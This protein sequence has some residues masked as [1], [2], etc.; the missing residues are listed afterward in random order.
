V[1]PADGGGKIDMKRSWNSSLWIG[2]LFA[3]AGFLSYTFFAQFPVTR[4]FPWANLLLFA[5]SA[6]FL[7]LGLFRGFGKTQV[8]RGKVFGP[9]L[10]TLGILMFG[11]FSYV[12]FYQLRQVPPSADA[13]HVGQKAP[14]FTLPD[15]NDKQVSL[16]EL[17]LSPVSSA[18]T[19]NAN[20]VLLIFYRGF[21]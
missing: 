1:D 8:Y 9:I 15:Q 5:A 3:L 10:A 13:P 16:A 6:I 4:D 18:S 20:G 11:F 7:V 21:W 17:L 2:F 19:A 14:E 12:F